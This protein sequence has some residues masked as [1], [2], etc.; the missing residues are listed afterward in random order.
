MTDLKFNNVKI[1][2]AIEIISLYIGLKLE[3]DKKLV[4]K[5]I[6][7]RDRIYLGDKGLVDKVLS[8]YGKKI[9][10]LLN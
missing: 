2:V 1:E 4:Q 9:K 8:E 10:E 3:N 5:L 7:E 6:E